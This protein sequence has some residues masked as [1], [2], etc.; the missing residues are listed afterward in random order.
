[1]IP[2][3]PA[4]GILVQHNWADCH[5]YTVACQCGSSD[6]NHSIWVEAEDTGVIVTTF[7]EQKTNFWSMTRWHHIWRLLTQGYVKYE[8]TIVMTEQQT[9]NYAETLKTA[10]LSVK[11]FKK[12]IGKTNGST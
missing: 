9:L 11:E 3:Q 2:Q 7:T 10:M 6:C 5:I 12:Q 8:A 1:M 4:E